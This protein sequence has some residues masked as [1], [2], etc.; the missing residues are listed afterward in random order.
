MTARTGSLNPSGFSTEVPSTNSR[1]GLLIA[2]CYVEVPGSEMSRTR[3][4]N[5][6]P[7]WLSKSPNARR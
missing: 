6:P 2:S 5:T 7:S 3:S 4:A 1:I